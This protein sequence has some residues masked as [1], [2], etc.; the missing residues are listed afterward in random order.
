MK[1]ALKQYMLS[2]EQGHPP[3][4]CYLSRIHGDGVPGLVKKSAAKAKEYLQKAVIQAT[5]MP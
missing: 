4:L 3:A 2:A 5:F 1:K